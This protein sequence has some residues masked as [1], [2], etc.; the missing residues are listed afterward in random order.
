MTTRFQAPR[1]TQD[2][3]PDMQP[4]WQAVNDAIRVVTRL[5]GFRRIDTPAFEYAGVFEKGSGDTTDIVEKEMYT[6]EDRGGERLALTPE[7]TP[8]ICRAYLE[9]GMASWP[10]PV[11]L[12]TTHQMFRYDRPQKGRYRQHTQFDCE[13]FGSTD[14]LV[15]AEVIAVLW[16]LYTMLGIRNAGVRLGSLDD[17][18]PRRAYVERLKDYYRP[19]LPKLSEDSQRRFERN[20]LRLL[21]SKDE[22]DLPFKEA[23]PKLVDNLSPEARAH[24]ETVLGAL[25]ATEIPVE[26]DPLLVRGLDYYNRTVFEIVPTDDARAQGT[27]GGG[28]RYDGLM[29]ILG[30]PP[31]PGMGFGSGIERIILEMQRSGV[32]FEN[33]AAADVYIVHKAE[34]A[35]AMVFGLASR[36]RSAGVAAVL[37][38]SNKSFKAQMRGANHSGAKFA[39]IIG[40]DELARGA[41]TVKDL[42]GEGEQESVELGR[43]PALLA[44]KL[45]A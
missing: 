7:G 19:H 44:A 28:G 27:I 8:A 4:Y 31:T 37:G 11:R 45:R 9:H 29:E 43:L 6:F 38:E 26:I 1:G 5:H 23:A 35:A 32:V 42:T 25:E 16:R 14:P 33:E 20:P 2:V 12:Y 17:I 10:Q 3:L 22:R 36:L 21:D 41:G 39:V 15:D 40:D 24:H 30:G 34:G 18:A 13:I